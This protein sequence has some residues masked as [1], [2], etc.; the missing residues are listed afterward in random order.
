MKTQIYYFTGTGNSLFVARQL[1]K[2]LDNTEV[3]SIPKVID[4]PLTVSAEAVGLIF[5]VYMWGMPLIVERFVDQLG[6]VK[7]IRDKYIFSVSTHGGMPAGTQLQLRDQ[8]RE[9]GLTLAAG[10]SIQ[11]P[12]NYTPLYGAKTLAVQAK[13]FAK[14]QKKIRTIAAVIKKKNKGEIEANNGLVNAF[15][16]GFVY[17]A[18]A[19][20]IPQMAKSFWVDGKCNHCRICVKICPV[21]NIVWENDLPKWLDKC[22]QCLACLQWCPQEAIQYGKN[23]A[24]RK[25]YHHPEVTFSDI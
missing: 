14:A 13:Q 11:M 15:F 2:E 3:I 10:Y 12:G 17:K 7:G 5:P 19:K 22:E 24:S 23:T 16:S 6:E 25:R 18:S 1:A 20:H 4:K 9:H 21:Q 8:L